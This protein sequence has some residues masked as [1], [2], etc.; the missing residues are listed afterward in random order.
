M[1]KEVIFKIKIKHLL[2]GMQMNY[3]N[4]YLIG[5]LINLDV[6]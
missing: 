5:M 6:N 3:L 1:R 2:L 4:Q